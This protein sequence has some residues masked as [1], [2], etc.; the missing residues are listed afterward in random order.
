[1]HVGSYPKLQLLRNM[2][3]FLFFPHWQ[4]NVMEFKVASLNIFIREAQDMDKMMIAYFMSDT[5]DKEV[6]NWVVI[7]ICF[8][9]NSLYLDSGI[10]LSN[11]FIVPGLF[12]SHYIF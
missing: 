1:M 4:P 9:I 3:K 5:L 7:P 12:H 10:E 6:H 2:N 11:Y 8:F